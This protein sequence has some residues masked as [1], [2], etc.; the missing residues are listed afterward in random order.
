VRAEQLV[1]EALEVAKQFSLDS[2]VDFTRTILALILLDQGRFEEA[3][4]SQLATVSRVRGAGKQDDPNLPFALTLMG[5]VLMENGD[6]ADAEANLI[7]GEALYRKL[8][9]PEYLAIYDNIRVQA[10]VAYMKGDYQS[11]KNKIDLALDNYRKNSIPKN[12]S[13]ATALTV[14]GLTLNKLGR[15]EEAEKV[16]REAVKLRVENLPEK[17]FMTALS[18]GALGEFLTT[19]KRFAEAEGLLLVSYENLKESQSADSP[20]IRTAAAR[21]VT[22]YADWGR[23]NDANNFRNR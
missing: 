14:Q 8:Y 5:S 15:S 4:A 3:K 2:Q 9:G 17:H 13:F 11:A 16:L 1:R 22:L 7:E 20:R 10:Q 19:Q 18:K 21:L 12:I 6:L 23:P